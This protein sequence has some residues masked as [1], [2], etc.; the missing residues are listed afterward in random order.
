MTTGDEVVLKERTVGHRTV[1]G[2]DWPIDVQ[3]IRTHWKKGSCLPRARALYVVH[4]LCNG[5]CDRRRQFPTLR[6]AQVYYD[7]QIHV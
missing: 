3:L 5:T 1:M 6:E 7:Q 2:T 4:E